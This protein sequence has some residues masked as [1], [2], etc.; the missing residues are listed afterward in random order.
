MSHLPAD[1]HHRLAALKLV[2]TPVPN[3]GWTQVLKDA[4]R[5]EADAHVGRGLRGITMKSLFDAGYPTLAGMSL[6]C[7]LLAVAE[8]MDRLKAEVTQWQCEYARA[9]IDWQDATT[10]VDRLKAEVFSLT[11]KPRG[12]THSCD[13]PGC[14]VCDPTYG[15]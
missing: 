12:P 5:T 3:A 9:D 15:L 6:Q 13:I 8:E 10:E 14:A 11:P 1:A 4:L 2:D 7:F